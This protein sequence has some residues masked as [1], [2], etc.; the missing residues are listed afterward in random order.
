MNFTIHKN[1]LNNTIFE[2]QNYNSV[3]KKLNR[4]NVKLL[5]VLNKSYQVIGSISDG[6]IRRK[7]LNKKYDEIKLNELM[8]KKPFLIFNGSSISKS[9]IRKFKHGIV[10][11][12]KKKILRN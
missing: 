11:D 7:G 2:Y 12:S 3:K 9:D 1:F 4:A 6:D 8:N 10:V 5:A